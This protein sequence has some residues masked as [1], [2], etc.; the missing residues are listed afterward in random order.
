[1]ASAT[2]MRARS[3]PAAPQSTRAGSNGV[4]LTPPAYGVDF[5]HAQTDGREALTKRFGAFLAGK[6][7]SGEMAPAEAARALRRYR[8]SEAGQRDLFFHD[9]AV[10]ALAAR[11]KLEASNIAVEGYQALAA[12]PELVASGR[13]KFLPN[14]RKTR[15]EELE[16]QLAEATLKARESGLEVVRRAYREKGPVAALDAAKD[17]ASFAADPVAAVTLIRQEEERRREA[18]KRTDLI[19]QAK[20]LCKKEMV[21]PDE[22]CDDFFDNL[23]Q[24]ATLGAEGEIEFSTAQLS[25]APAKNW[26]LTAQERANRESLLTPDEKADRKAVR[27]ARV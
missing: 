12:A 22:M 2:P 20:Y 23:D 3:A 11:Q 21:A 7:A 16:E 24:Q 27:D 6:I 13:Y 5:V 25:A 4:A 8:S 19:R 9:N 18:E 17:I 14:Y 26:Q 15:V 10:A 1:M